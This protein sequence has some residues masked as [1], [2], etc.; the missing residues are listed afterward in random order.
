MAEECNLNE[1][2]CSSDMDVVGWIEILKQGKYV[3]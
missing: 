1:I 2:T 3:C